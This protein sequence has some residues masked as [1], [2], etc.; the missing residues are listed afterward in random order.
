M[1]YGVLDRYKKWVAVGNAQPPFGPAV[2]VDF[3]DDTSGTAHYGSYPVYGGQVHETPEAG[4]SREAPHE[5]SNEYNRVPSFESNAS[6]ELF[7]PNTIDDIMNAVVTPF[8]G[9]SESY[10]SGGMERRIDG[11]SADDPPFVV[12]SLSFG[13]LFGRAF[14]RHGFGGSEN[15]E[16][17]SRGSHLYSSSSSFSRRMQSD[18]TVVEERTVRHPNGRV[19]RSRVVTDAQGGEVREEIIP[20]RSIGESAWIAQGL[21]GDLHSL[22]RSG[23]IADLALRFRKWMSGG[24]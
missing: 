10:S 13:E 19:E 24:S 7:D 14:E 17:D 15:A 3:Y 6:V 8:G 12:P 16:D 21:P 5:R 18:G 11:E 9:W 22:D 23:R 4:A 1:V 2:Q 20:D